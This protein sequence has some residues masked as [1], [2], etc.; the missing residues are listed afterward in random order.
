MLTRSFK[1]FGVVS[2]IRETQRRR[3]DLALRNES[4]ELVSAFQ[5][6]R[7]FRTIQGRTVER[8]FDD[9]F[10]RQRYV[11][12]CETRAARA[13]SVSSAGG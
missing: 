3:L 4:A 5:D 10:I 1:E 12:A 13:R 9:L 6:I 7:C 11:E 2:H 8:R